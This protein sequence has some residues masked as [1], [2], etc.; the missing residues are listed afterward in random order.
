MTLQPAGHRA[1]RP[2]QMSSSPPPS[3][4]QPSPSPSSTTPSYEPVGIFWDYGQLILT[5]PHISKLKPRQ[6]TARHPP[7][8]PDTTLSR[9]SASWQTSSGRSTSSRRTSSF[10]TSPLPGS[11]PS[12]P[13]FSPV[14]CPSPVRPSHPAHVV[15]VLTF[16]PRLSAQ[17]EELGRLDDDRRVV[18][19][20]WETEPHSSYLAQWM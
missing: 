8:P 1:D 3:T 2:S 16:R 5:L 12:G 13:N 18:S 14:A 19:T 4:E 10:Q 15:S 11:H 7:M 6:R 17:W 9:T 20:A